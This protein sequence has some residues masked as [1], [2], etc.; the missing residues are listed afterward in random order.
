M[1]LAAARGGVKT[2]YP[3]YRSTLDGTT[4]VEAGSRPDDPRDRVRSM[5]AP[6]KIADQSP[7]DGEVHVL[8]VQGNV[9]MLVADGTNITVSV[10]PEGVALVNTGAAAHVRQDPR[11]R[12]DSWRRWSW[13]ADDQPMRRRDVPRNLGLVQSLYQHGHQLPGRD[14]AHPLHRQHQ[15]GA[16]ARRRQRE[17]SRRWE[18]GSAPAGWVAPSTTVEGRAGHRA[19]KRAQPDERAGREAGAFAAADLADGELLRRVLQASRVLQRGRGGG[20]S[21]ARGQHGRRQ[22]RR[23]PPF[24]GHQRRRP[25]LDRQLSGDRRRKGRKRG[26][27]DRRA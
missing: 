10:G 1:P 7:R 21:R 18:P 23:V 4:A 11:R 27:R 15:R 20:L 16:R 3:E 13:P 6:K 19:R 24:G 17:D 5:S 22:H 2:L 9:Y 14:T 26:R 8:P 12:S 25:L